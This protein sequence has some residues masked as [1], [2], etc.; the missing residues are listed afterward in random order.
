[1]GASSISTKKGIAPADKRK[2]FFEKYYPTYDAT[3]INPT[4]LDGTKSGGD[5]W[6]R[7]AKRGGRFDGEEGKR[8]YYFLTRLAGGVE[9]PDAPGEIIQGVSDPAKVIPAGWDY[10]K[11]KGIP[12]EGYDPTSLKNLIGNRFLYLKLDLTANEDTLFRRVKTITHEYR[13]QLNLDGR[14]R[15]AKMK[16]LAYY[17]VEQIALE[18]KKDARSLIAKGRSEWR[19]VEKGLSRARKEVI[20]L[21]RTLKLPA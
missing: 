17:R 3:P 20:R 13:R 4:A 12:I 18:K 14:N 5:W 21:F 10:E 8:D 9:D 15:E 11:P 6:M 2:T 19:G 16:Y 7:L 1:M